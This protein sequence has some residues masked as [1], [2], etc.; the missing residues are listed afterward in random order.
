M[1]PVCLPIANKHWFESNLKIVGV[2]GYFD[3]DDTKTVQYE[4]QV[5]KTMKEKLCKSD[6]GAHVSLTNFNK[7][8]TVSSDFLLKSHDLCHLLRNMLTKYNFRCHY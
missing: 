3:D 8:I 6:L 2:N 4:R 1:Q 7:L 5:L